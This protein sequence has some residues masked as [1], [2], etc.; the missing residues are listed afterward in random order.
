MIISLTREEDKKTLGH[1][2][3]IL[4]VAVNMKA[5]GHIER[6]NK[7]YDQLK[8]KIDGDYTE[9]DKRRIRVDLTLNKIENGM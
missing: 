8:E 2:L 3:E 9:E 7:W 4:E 1:I 6:L 5:F